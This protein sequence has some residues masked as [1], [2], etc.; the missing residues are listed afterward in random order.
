MGEG[1]RESEGELGVVVAAP[2][3]SSA[4]SR[5]IFHVGATM[6]TTALKIAQGCAVVQDGLARRVRPAP[7]DEDAES[8]AFDVTHGYPFKK[9]MGSGARPVQRSFGSPRAHDGRGPSE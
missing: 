5:R 4:R 8:K 3:A 9:S 2:A 1:G 7:A 6:E